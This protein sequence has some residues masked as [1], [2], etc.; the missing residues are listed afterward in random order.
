MAILW[1]MLNQL[2][3]G[4]VHLDHILHAAELVEVD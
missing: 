1:L 2:M 4:G 3:E